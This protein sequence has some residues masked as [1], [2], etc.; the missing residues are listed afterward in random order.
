MHNFDA[1]FAKFSRRACAQ[2]DPLVWLGI[3]KQICKFSMQLMAL[4]R[5]IFSRFFQNFLGGM[6]LD[7]SS[8]TR[9]L[10]TF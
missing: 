7:L 6:P 9:G 1:I 3:Y 10:Q 2:P 8:M 4:K 5:A